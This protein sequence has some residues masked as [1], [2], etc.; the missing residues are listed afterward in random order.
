[1]MIRRKTHMKSI[2]DDILRILTKANL[3]DDDWKE[4]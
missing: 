2:G 4:I 1:M 3:T